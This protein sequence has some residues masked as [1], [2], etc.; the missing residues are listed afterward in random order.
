MEQQPRDIPLPWAIAVLAAIVVAGSVAIWKYLYRPAP[1]PNAIRA[2]A[3]P[4]GMR[5]VGSGKPPSNADALAIE[6]EAELAD[7][8]YIKDDKALFKAG[9][10]YLKSTAKGDDPRFGFY[11]INDL[12]WDHGYLSLALRRIEAD[13][14]FV[15]EL[16]LTKEQVQKLQNLPEAPSGKW[17]DADRARFARMLDEWGRANDQAAKA[18][19]I[20]KELG[21]YAT[22][23]RAAVDARIADRVKII[24][25]TLT[26]E[27]LAKVNPIPRWNLP[28]TRAATRPATQR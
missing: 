4:P 27:Q 8:V 10:A 22:A 16:G 20:L 28:T 21:T 2:I 26:P 11:S 12:E 13:E 3:P 18:Q 19:E 5:V 6:R 9:D 7:G 23:R 15:K 14:A 25:T 24:K 17:P 1:A